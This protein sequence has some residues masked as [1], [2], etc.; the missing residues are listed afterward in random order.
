MWSEEAASGGRR[1]PS[2]G[3]ALS[4]LLMAWAW[5]PDSEWLLGALR[6]VIV[7][8]P[9]PLNPGQHSPPS[10]LRARLHLI[11]PQSMASPLGTLRCVEGSSQ[12]NCPHL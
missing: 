9:V 7:P 12:R 11:P 3:N 4:V 1:L 8:A 2:A 5:S 10:A 6:V